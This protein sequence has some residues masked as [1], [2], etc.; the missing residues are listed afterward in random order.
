MSYSSINIHGV[1]RI[2]AGQSEELDCGGLMTRLSLHLKDGS[3]MSVT[4]F[5][6]Q[7][8]CV[9][10]ERPLYPEAVTEEAAA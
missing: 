6:D 2:E 10:K 5:S 9:E 1:V 4:A 7:P 3:L 8:L